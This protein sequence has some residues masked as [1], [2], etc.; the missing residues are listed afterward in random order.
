MAC[1]WKGSDVDGR[2]MLCMKKI[3]GLNESENLAIL[4]LAKEESEVA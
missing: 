3:M 2:D 1:E 4:C